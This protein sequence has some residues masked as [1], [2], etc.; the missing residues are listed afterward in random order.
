MT[1]SVGATSVQATQ[2]VTVSAARPVAAFTETVDGLGV[3]VDGSASTAASGATITGYAWSWGD[4]QPDSTGA[5]ATHTYAAAGTYPVTLTVTDSRGVTGS[6]TKNVVV[7]AAAAVIAEDTFTRTS[8]TGWG[9]AD[10]GGTW[11]GSAG[12]PSTGAA[13]C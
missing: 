9:T 2:T 8:A 11:S 5:T 4:G 7:Q 3:A 1:D 10:V 12:F 6:I 13:A